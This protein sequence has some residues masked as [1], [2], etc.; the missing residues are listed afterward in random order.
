[1]P[2]C[3]ARLPHPAPDP[4]LGCYQGRPLDSILIRSCEQPIKVRLQLVNQDVLKLSE[5]HS[6]DQYLERSD[7]EGL[8]GVI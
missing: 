8:I 3:D 2:A 7:G 5:Q 1:M 6:G 4:D